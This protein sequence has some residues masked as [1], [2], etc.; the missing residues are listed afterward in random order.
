MNA[1][2]ISATKSQCVFD[3]LEGVYSLLVSGGS[4]GP[5]R[6]R[7]QRR[8]HHV[9][10]AAGHARRGVLIGC[11]GT[12]AELTFSDGYRQ[13]PYRAALVYALRRS[14]AASRVSVG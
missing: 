8:R 1:R 6:N 5:I 2:D 12:E 7:A 3:E 13:G 14:A 4:R 10:S 11:H 9:A